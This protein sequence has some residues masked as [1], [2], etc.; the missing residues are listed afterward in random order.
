[1]R[2][3]ALAAV[4]LASIGALVTAG[5]LWRSPR[6]PP[7]VVIVLVDTLRADHT[8]LHG[9]E[10]QTTPNL[11]RI[12]SRGLVMRSHFA[13][14]PWTKPSVASLITGLHP[15]AHRS[16]VGQF[17]TLEKIETLRRQGLTPKIEILSEKHLTLA[18][19]LR[20]AGYRTA[21][22]VA[23]YHLTPRFG[24]D[25]GYE[26]YRFDPNRYRWAGMKPPFT[27]LDDEEIVRLTIEHLRINDEPVFV[28][29]HLMAVHDYQYPESFADRAFRPQSLTPIDES[30]LQYS[31]V[32]RYAHLEE[33]IAEYDTSIAYV[34]QLVGRLFDYVR[35]EEPNTLLIITSDHGEEFY[36]HG[37]FEHGHTL[38][39]ELLH[40]PLVLWGPDVPVGSTSAPSDSVDLLPTIVTAVGL[41]A[42]AELTGEPLFTGRG[43]TSGKREI[44]AEMHYRVPFWRFALV[45][46]GRKLIVTKKAEGAEELELYE[47]ALG[48]EIEDV[49]GRVDDA[50]LQLFRRRVQRWR[51]HVDAQFERLVGDAERTDLSDYDL[52][53][54]E[55]LGYIR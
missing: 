52:E 46:D 21:A 29:C 36:E 51:A 25:Q 11:E 6:Q 13:N 8:S 53:Q 14:S 18:E 43:V 50:E 3:A 44:F 20:A 22:F 38:Y 16:R 12:A 2:R 42:E 55:A 7:N 26:D 35:Q 41:E 17:E 27:K 10:R 23:N 40:V 24:Y 32:K 54:L 33:A 49:S 19:R 45:R 9:Y 30:G 4:G 37:G 31:R 34:D 28:W 5:L 48:R 47:D 15:S 39:N 1:M